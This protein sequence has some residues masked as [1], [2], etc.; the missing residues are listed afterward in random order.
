[1]NVAPELV[2]AGREMFWGVG[3]FGAGSCGFMPRTLIER[4]YE[5]EVMIHIY[6]VCIV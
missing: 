4:K 2:L 6:I 5:P 3:M 1:M